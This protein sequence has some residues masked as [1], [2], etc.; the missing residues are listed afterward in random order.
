VSTPLFLTSLLKLVSDGPYYSAELRR[1]SAR[2]LAN[3]SERNSSQ[4]LSAVDNDS[5]RSWINSVDDIKDERLRT[6]ANRA[7]L[8]LS[9][10]NAVY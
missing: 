9:N 6:H 1:E 10:M 5:M 3:I 8:S 7:K 2:V 4:I